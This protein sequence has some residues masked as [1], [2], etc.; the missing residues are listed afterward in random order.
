MKKF[1]V[2][3]IGFGLVGQKRAKNLGPKA[4]LVACSDIIN[5]KKKFLDQKNNKIKFFKNWK[6]L[7]KLKELDIIII[8][9]VH[10]LLAPILLEACRNKKNILVEKP[11][12]I[13]LKDLSKIIKLSKKNKNKIRVGYNHRFHSAIIKSKEIID[14]KLLGKLMFIK[15]SYGHGGRLGYEK[16]WRMKS[17]IS[18]GGELI[19]QGSHLI[20][21]SIFFLGKVK[22]V[23]S[24]LE[25]FFWNT[26][27]D[28]NAFITLKFKNN[29]ISFLHASCTEWKNNFI[30]EIYGT[31][32]K[33]KIEGKGGSY[34]RENL[35]FYKMSKKM[36]PPTIKKWF[37]SKND[38]S[39][40]TELNELY[41]DINYNRNSN[42]G[43]DQAY[44]VLKIIKNIYKANKY[45][46]CS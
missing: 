19:D 44:S 6:D 18:G 34:G 25:N 7:I 2:G 43:L 23:T 32:G 28:D 36:G 31:K 3:I 8:S 24:K 29:C 21:L 20:D 1:K 15:A 16:E 12:A 37:F 33:L 5:I 35:V 42:P 4:E 10:N 27:V 30:F 26:N 17:K 11:A 41:N 14:K 40:K 45:D 13:H 46:H 39:W 38:N 9:T 22:K